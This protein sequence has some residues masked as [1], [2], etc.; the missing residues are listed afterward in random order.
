[1]E[2]TLDSSFDTP[3]PSATEASLNA[4]S[5]SVSLFHDLA[6]ERRSG[7]IQTFSQVYYVC[8]ATI[9][10]SGNILNLAVMSKS[11]MSALSST[12][13]LKGLAVADILAL[14]FQSILKYTV[15]KAYSVHNPPA[16]HVYLC[17][18]NNWVLVGAV[19]TTFWITVGFTIERYVAIAHPLWGKTWC[20]VSRAK[21][22][23][24]TIFVCAFTY[25]IYN[26]IVRYVDE[27]GECVFRTGSL[28]AAMGKMNAVCYIVTYL[29]V[30][31]FNGRLSG[32]TGC[33]EGKDQNASVV[34]GT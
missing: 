12:V 5:V 15:F 10:I 19:R 28:Q 1:M 4:V 13:Y 7:P 29:L 21:K 32:S 9:G 25:S 22:S 31:L 24:V 18:Y 27:N 17:V 2:S 6:S 34:A 33:L 11:S 26:L 16:F 30:A 20:T 14:I 3:T 23:L 8:L